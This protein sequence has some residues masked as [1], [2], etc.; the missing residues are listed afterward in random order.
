MPKIGFAHVYQQLWAMLRED[1][2]AWCT[3]NILC[4]FDTENIVFYQK[5]DLFLNRKYMQLHIFECYAQLS[6]EFAEDSEDNIYKEQRSKISQL[7]HQHSRTDRLLLE[8]QMKLRKKVR[9]G[10]TVHNKVLV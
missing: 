6:R 7:P 10:S 5:I 8:I 4:I 1:H 9:D 3:K 2:N